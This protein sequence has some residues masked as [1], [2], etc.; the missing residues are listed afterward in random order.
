VALSRGQDTRIAEW[1]DRAVDEAR[2]QES[3]KRR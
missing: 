3:I 2:E 1:L